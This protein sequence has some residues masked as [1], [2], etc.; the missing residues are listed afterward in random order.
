MVYLISYDL[1]KMKNY[2]VLRKAIQSLGNCISPLESFW[3]VDTSMT[4]SQLNEVISK[5]VDSDDCFY[6]VPIKDVGVGKLLG[7]GTWDWIKLKLNI[8]PL[9]PSLKSIVKNPIPKN[10]FP[11]KF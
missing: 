9:A 7:T 10:P 6:I 2:P 4:L 8:V 11:P 3:L 5:A 1:H